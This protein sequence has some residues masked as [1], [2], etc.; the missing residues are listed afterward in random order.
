MH[1]P[2]G[3]TRSPRSRLATS[4]LVSN[5]AILRGMAVYVAID[6]VCRLLYSTISSSWL[7]PTWCPDLRNLNAIV[8]EKLQFLVSWLLKLCDRLKGSQSKRGRVGE[9]KP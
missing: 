7:T 3:R 4:G 9:L 6:T 8:R 1:C 5:C 2:S